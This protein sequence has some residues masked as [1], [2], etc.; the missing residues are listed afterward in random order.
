MGNYQIDTQVLLQSNFTNSGGTATD[1]TVVSLSVRAP[2]GTL[3]IYP[4]ASLTRLSAGVWTFLLTLNES[5]TWIY[6]WQGTG[7]L[8]VTSADTPILVISSANIPG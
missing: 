1:P 7:A 3:T 5:G 8:I 2:D 4:Q 6:K